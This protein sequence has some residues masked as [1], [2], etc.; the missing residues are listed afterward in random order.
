[1]T[2]RRLRI[3][4]VA[5]L[6]LVSTF[7]AVRMGAADDPVLEWIEDV[8][9]GPEYGGS[10]AIAS[11]WVRAPVLKLVEGSTEDRRVVE[12]CVAEIN[13]ALARTPIREIVLART[14]VAGADILVYSV[15]L[16]RFPELARRHGFQYVEG[17][18]GFFWTFWNERHEIQS[19][20]VLLASDRLSETALRHIALVE[21]TQSLG[22]SGDS[23]VFPESVFFSRDDD[24]GAAEHLSALDR[25]LIDFFYR[26]L[27]PGARTAE[28]RIAYWR[29][30]ERE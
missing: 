19:A 27:S 12:A 16:H 22:L 17:N 14:G 3:A 6:A 28:V 5:A 4:R 24:G 13:S 1:M 11:R 20:V 29:H 25:Q 15:P 21:I 18:L 10:G 26:Y 9:L 7:L 8:V 30:W 2:G 23:P